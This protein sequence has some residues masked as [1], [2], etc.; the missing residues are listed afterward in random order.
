MTK[1]NVTVSVEQSGYLIMQAVAHL[2]KA[3]KEAAKTGHGFQPG[4]DLPVIIAEAAKDLPV[5]LS[6]IPLLSGEIGEDKIAF[7]KGINLGT[8]EVIDSLTS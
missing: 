5:I 2:A 7:A 6:Q 3:V 8:W 4:E 1:I